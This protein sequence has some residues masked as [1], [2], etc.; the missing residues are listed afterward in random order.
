MI[1]AAVAAGGALLFGVLPMVGRL[2]TPHAEPPSQP[3]PPGTFRATDQQWATLKFVQA[4]AGDFQVRLQT[5]GKI[6]TDDDVTTQVFSP[7]SGRVTRILVKAGDRVK[8]GQPLF[9]VQA[10]EIAQDRSD[11]AVASAQARLAAA[12]EARMHA[13]YE[14]AGGALKDW[15]QSQSDLAAAQA[16]LQ[17]ARS[18]LKILGKNDADIAALEHAGANAGG[19]T[20]VTAP[21]S[22]VATQRLIGVGQTIASVTN[23]GANPAFVISDLSKVWL[24]ADVRE[25]DSARVHLGQTLQVRTLALPGRVFSARV[26]Y[27]APTIDP[28]TRRLTVRAVLANPDGALKPEMFASFALAAG[29]S[30]K[31]VTVPQDAV[32][33]E[34]DTA[35][36]WVA[37]PRSR[38]L[39][40][41]QIDAGVTEDGRVQV[42]G[43]LSP[44]D[45]V[46][47]SGALFIDRAAKSH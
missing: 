28:T 34:G 36:V 8:A 46:V 41:R 5:D 24:T 32:I 4:Q 38:S 21:I 16:A 10:A 1:L 2:L 47:T 22:G 13:L 6:A 15:Q 35:R 18:R 17:A 20:M 9:E 11:L 42:I 31:A 14:S 39:E 43:G 29:P 45:W 33:F 40:L 23:G 25:A 3:S 26:D 37:D 19:A 27:V 7:Y 12:N 30:Q 44:G